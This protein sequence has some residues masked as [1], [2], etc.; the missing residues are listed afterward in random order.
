MAKEITEIEYSSNTK[1]SVIY[2]V[3]PH[4]LSTTY[5]KTIFQYDRFE[6]RRSW[7][8]E[9]TSWDYEMLYRTGLLGFLGKDNQT[10]VT[11]W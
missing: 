11:R 10:N 9:N 5:P 2:S 1:P 8:L 4:C 3:L 6:K 7:R